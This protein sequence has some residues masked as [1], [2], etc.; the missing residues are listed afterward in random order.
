MIKIVSRH[1]SLKKKIHLNNNKVDVKRLIENH[2][3]FIKSYKI[4][5]K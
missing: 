1:L 3:E 5:L 2:K 4:I